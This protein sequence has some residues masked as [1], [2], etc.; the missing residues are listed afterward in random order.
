MKAF[1]NYEEAKKNAAYRGGAKLPAGGY[2]AKIKDVRYE[3]GQDG[4]SDVIVLAYDIIEGEYKDFFKKQFEENTSED[5]KWKGKTTIYVPRDDGTEQDQ[6]TQNAF[7]RWT[8]AFENSNDGYVWDWDEK[9]WK[10]KTVGLIYGDVG[11]VI[12]GKPV[13]F[14]ECRFPESADNI[15]KGNFKLPGFKARKGFSEARDKAADAERNSDKGFMN[16]PD[17]IDEDIPF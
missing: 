13:E 2:V 14:T 5:K 6:W 9:K 12:E 17:G 4:R 8:T 16:V 15:R 7:A 1:N 10:G 3:E 11:A